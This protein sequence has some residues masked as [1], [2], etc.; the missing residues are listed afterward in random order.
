LEGHLPSRRRR[1]V[2]RRFKG[3]SKDIEE[4][5]KRMSAPPEIGKTVPRNIERDVEEFVLGI[6]DWRVSNFPDLLAFIGL[7]D[8]MSKRQPDFLGP[9]LAL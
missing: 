6:T 7:S 9:I 4:I 3:I 8:L 1:S 5:S 2:E